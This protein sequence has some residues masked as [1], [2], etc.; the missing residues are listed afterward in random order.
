[1]PNEILA[2]PDKYGGGEVELP[3]SELGKALD[4]KLKEKGFAVEKSEFEDGS[5]IVHLRRRYSKEGITVDYKKGLHIP[6]DGEKGEIDY[7]GFD[8]KKVKLGDDGPH[9]SAETLLEKLNAAHSGLENVY[10]EHEG[11]CVAFW[12]RGGY[13]QKPLRL[14]ADG[15][16]YSPEAAEYFT[17]LFGIK[18]EEMKDKKREQEE[19]GPGNRKYFREVELKADTDFLVAKVEEIIAFAESQK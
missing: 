11:F 5:E 4:A 3:F 7:K 16:L 2:L 17:H 8:P 1:M 19:A 12:M 18:P 9:I 13:N 15:E 10:V 6:V 14:V